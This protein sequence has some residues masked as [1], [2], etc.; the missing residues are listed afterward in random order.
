MKKILT[1]RRLWTVLILVVLVAAGGVT[2]YV[3]TGHQ[4]PFGTSGSVTTT[5]GGRRTGGGNFARGGAAAGTGGGNFTAVARQ[6]ARVALQ[7]AQVAAGLQP[8]T[9]PEPQTARLIRRQP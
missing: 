4:L 9:E 2:Y 1:S 8:Q 6:P 7:L 5:G 3:L